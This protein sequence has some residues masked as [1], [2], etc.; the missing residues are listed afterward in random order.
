MKK[1]NP[2]DGLNPNELAVA[3]LLSVPDGMRGRLQTL[4]PA[5]MRMTMSEC[6]DELRQKDVE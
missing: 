2:V 1:Q 3:V 6:R 4:V 5:D